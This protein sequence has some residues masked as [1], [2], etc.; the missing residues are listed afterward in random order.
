MTIHPQ[1]ANL[2]FPQPVSEND[3]TSYLVE[4]LGLLEH[5]EGGWF[6]ETD[7]SPFVMDSPYE[8]S[9]TKTRNYSTLIYYYLSP[10]RPRGKLHKNK[11][12][13][14]HMLHRGSGTYVVLHKDGTIETFEVGHGPGQRMQ[15]VVE[16]GTYK[17]SFTHD[18]EGLLISE[19][20]VPGFDFD[21]HNFM[22]S[23]QELVKWVGDSNA[24]VLQE[25]L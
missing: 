12:R 25:L 20:V 9:K 11:S 22:K 19:V 16:G 21:D 18:N 15:W 4:S 7:R 23:K 6:L 17:A 1:I 10:S 14:I 24:E 8:D 13:I 5:P 2:K 3:T